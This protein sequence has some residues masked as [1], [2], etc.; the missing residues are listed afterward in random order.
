MVKH[1][2]G[3]VAH[4][5]LGFL[6]EVAQHRGAVPT[7]EQLYD[8]IV[9][10]ATEEGH[11]ASGTTRSRG[12]GVGSDARSVEQDAGSIAELPGDVFRS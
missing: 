5:R 9:A 4:D 10:A 11:G 1:F 2:R 8:I 12:D 7:A 6:M 3:E